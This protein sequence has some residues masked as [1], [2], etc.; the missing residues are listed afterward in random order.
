MTKAPLE[1]IHKAEVHTALTGHPTDAETTFQEIQT[2]TVHIANVPAMH[3]PIATT[4]TKSQ[5]RPYPLQTG[6]NHNQEHQHLHNTRRQHNRLLRHPPLNLLPRTMVTASQSEY[7]AASPRQT[8]HSWIY[9]TAC[10]QHMTYNHLFFSTYDTFDAPIEVHGINGLLMA[11]GQGNV[12]VMDRN[13]NKHT[14]LNV[15][16]VPGLGDSIISKYWTKH[17]GLQMTMDAH[18]NLHLRSHSGFHVSTTVIDKITIIENIKVLEYQEPQSTTVANAS[19]TKS[20]TI[21]T[22]ITHEDAKLWHQRLAHT[23]ADR[24]HLLRINYKPGNCHVCIMAK[25][26]RKPFPTNT[27]P[28]ATR[29]LERVFS[30]LCYITP[31]TFGHG[32]YLIVFVDELTRYVWVYII[33]NKTSSTI[34]QIIKSWL[35]LAQTQSDGHK[36]MY[37]RT[38]EGGEYTGETLNTVSPYLTELGVTHEQTSA[39]SS[40]SNG[41]AERMNR[42]L[43]D[44]VRAMMITSG[45]PAP[46]WG[47]AVHTA[48]KIR[49]RLPTSSLDNNIS[50]H[51]AWFGVP[52]SIKHIRVFGCV[53]Y[54]RILHPRT[55][56]LSRSIKCC[57]L[58]YQGTTQYRL[59][60]PA[61]NKVLTRI[62][63]VDF[64][65]HE[66]LPATAFTE[67][68]YAERPL[69]VPEPRNYSE[70]D[71][72][73]DDPDEFES[74]ELESDEFEP[75]EP[76]PI[77][78]LI[79]VPMPSYIPHAAGET[80]PAAVQP[81]RWPIPPPP[82]PSSTADSET[83]SQ[84]SS[85]TASQPTSRPSTPEHEA[86]RRST[87]PPKPTEKKIQGAAQARKRSTQTNKTL[88]AHTGP[89]LH[90]SSPHYVASYAPPEE[91]KTLAEA[92]A[93]PYAIYWY[94]AIDE[95]LESM[96]KHGTYTIVPRP[97]QSQSHRLQVRLQ[98]QK[99]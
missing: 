77:P 54:A 58:G 42:T 34:L 51:E 62:R 12:I 19:I 92:L 76:E 63:H 83:P 53:A 65:E 9:D 69:Q 40:A 91:P 37:F 56:V 68:P 97:T 20:A 26:T 10:T 1:A 39:H 81:V 21:R 23:S 16:Y 67:V 22:L 32:L 64:L 74:D 45:L 28:R 44:M 57:L 33:P 25:Q 38:D 86:V 84:H 46:F 90:S 99:R 4:D 61:A 30:D 11:L 3:L 88:V 80:T 72:E 8:R 41:I 29:K 18:E 75:E 14:L 5:V 43:M 31:E 94:G 89:T 36:L 47:E 17:S 66:F 13:G 78:E 95:E 79:E 27:N 85:P 93:S 98:D 50:P 7:V 15:W 60:D 49:N 48:A 59:Y 52:A 55:K 70:Q 82:R 73:S 87:R 71:E 35:A 2:P 24:L 6:V 96:N